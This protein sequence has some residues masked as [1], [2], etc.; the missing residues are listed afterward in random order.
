VTAAPDELCLGWLCEDAQAIGLRVVR[1]HEP[2][3]GDSLTAAAL[4]PAA[5]RLVSHLPLALGSDRREVRHMTA[6]TDT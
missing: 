2:D 3:L 5:R 6:S 1:F 4:E